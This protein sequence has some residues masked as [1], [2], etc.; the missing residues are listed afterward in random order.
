LA[1]ALVQGGVKVASRI[2][3]NRGKGHVIVLAEIPADADLGALAKAVQ[4]ADTPHKDQVAPALALEVFTN[5]RDQEAAD[6]A[7]EALKAVEG[8]DVEGSVVNVETGA[9]GVKL[10]GEAAVTV[11]AVVKAL[12]EAGLAPEIRVGADQAEA[13]DEA[14]N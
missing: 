1:D 12:D 14:G 2:A 6:K 13:A 7:R 9:M 3:P 11:D 4:N 5:A 10:T 8:V